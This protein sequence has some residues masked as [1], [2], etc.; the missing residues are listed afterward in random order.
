MEPRS[1]PAYAQ[2]RRRGCG[3]EVVEVDEECDSLVVEVWYPRKKKRCFGGLIE[4][5]EVLMKIWLCI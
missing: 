1:S 4:E 2:W 5:M 3:G